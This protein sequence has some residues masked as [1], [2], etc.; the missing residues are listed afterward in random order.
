MRGVTLSAAA[1]APALFLLY[2]NWPVV[3]SQR[4]IIPA[5]TVVLVPVL[6]AIAAIHQLVI[7]RRP[8]VIDRTLLLMI[9]FLGVLLLSA[10]P[11]QGYDLAFERITVFVSE[12]LLIYFLV[13]Q[14]VRSLPDLRIAILATLAAAGLLAGLTVFQ[15]V[16]GNYEQEFMGLVPRTLEHLEGLPASAREEVSLEDRARGPVDEPNRFAQILLMAGALAVVGTLNAARKRGTVVGWLFV[17]LLLAGVLLTYSRGALVTL[18]ALLLV[19]VPLGLM[20]PRH[21]VGALAI[22]GITVFTLVPGMAERAATMTGVAGLF[23]SAQVEADGPTRGRTTAMLSALAAYTDHPVL[24]VGPGQYTAFHAVKYQSLPEISFRE[25]AE[26]RRAHNLYLEMAAETGTVGLVV[27]LAIP[28]LLLLD[29]RGLRLSLY[30]RDRPD[31][32]RLATG[33]TLVLLAY[34]GTGIFLHLA[35]ERYYW[36]MVAL[37]ACTVGALREWV[38]EDATY[39]DLYRYQEVGPT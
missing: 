29:L 8:L 27:F 24:G 20:R 9:G 23:G 1:T 38:W 19:A 15:S 18:V 28:F 17:G 5:A 10:V 34:L 22:G 7:R 35:Y 37:T 33:F 6:L 26:P 2:T 21:L 3:A 36:I 4:G 30:W 13:R 16:T 14:S 31:L 25:I 39:C 11:A 12:G 32:A